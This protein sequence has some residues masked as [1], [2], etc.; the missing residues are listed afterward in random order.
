MTKLGRRDFLAWL[1]GLGF[2]HAVVGEPPPATASAVRLFLGG[3]L[4]S[5]RAIDQILPFSNPP[6]IHEPYLHDA[7]D[8]IALAERRNGPIPSPVTFEYVWGDALAVLAAMRPE[9]RIVNL[10]TAITT[11]DRYLP[12]GI[13][14]RMHPGNIGLLRVAQL[15]CCVLANNHVLD[16]DVP[17]L[18]STLDTLRAAGIATAGAGPDR[19]T[20]QAPAVIPLAGGRRVLVFAFALADSGAPRAWNAGDG[21]PGI[22][23]LPDLSPATVASI[24]RRAAGYR[25][26]GDLVVLSL[27]W[28]GN[29]GYAIDEAQRRFAHALI[30]AAAVDVLH[31]HSAHHVKGIE[32]YRGRPIIYGCGDL[33]NDYEGIRGYEAYRPDLGLLYF[34]T[35]DS[36]SGRL[37]RFDLV[38]VRRCR[39]RLQLADADE[40]AWL[41]AVLA[42]ESASLA[43]GIHAVDGPVPRLVVETESR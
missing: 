22:A 38:P 39:L 2:A 18:G 13:N 12:K 9:V 15:D 34:P 24:A 3:D 7:R 25:R 6:E 11:Y 36:L 4:M 28:G 32:V 16:W 30:D 10:E 29:W 5:G 17:G 20:A 43:T 8:Y 14:Y 23:L 42:R 41:H 26:A 19:A 27:H 31:G 35:L 1:T 33:L 37:L 40:T 21:R